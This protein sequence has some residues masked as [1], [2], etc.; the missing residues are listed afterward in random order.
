MKSLLTALLLA[1]CSPFAQPC[2]AQSKSPH[3]K[4]DQ[5]CNAC[6]T[7]SGWKEIRFE[8]Q[9]T[10]FPLA[11]Q[12]ALQHCLDCHQ[13]DNL[14]LATPSCDNCHVDY[15]QAALGPECGQCHNAEAWYPSDFAHDMTAFPLWGAHEAIDCVQC[16]ANEMTFQFAQ[17]AQSCFDCHTQDFARARAVVHLQAAID[18]ETCHT[19]DQWQGGHNPADFE[20]RA[21]PHEVNCNRCHKRGDDFLSYTCAECHEFSLN[22][23]E[24]RGIDPLD[25][26][27]LDCHSEGEIE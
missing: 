6:H 25:A 11:G 9:Q 19:Q 23:E 14:T 22:E 1:T 4:M 20:I 16:H 5:S 13:I 10:G 18:C 26:R 21:S 15:H 17:E 24:H 27:C 2:Q 7:T 8:H 12:H 3:G